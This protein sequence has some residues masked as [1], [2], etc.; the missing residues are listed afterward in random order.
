[1]YS[2]RRFESDGALAT[3]L[4]RNHLFTHLFIG[5]APLQPLP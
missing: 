3:E 2:H 1:M 4:L 5:V